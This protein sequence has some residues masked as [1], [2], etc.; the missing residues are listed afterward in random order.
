MENN[1]LKNLVLGFVIAMVGSTS[2]FADYK[3]TTLAEYRQMIKE[4][5]GRCISRIFPKD[6]LL[7][8]DYALEVEMI[9]IETALWAA[10]YRT[11]PTFVNRG[12]EIGGVCLI[13]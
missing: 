13:K 12:R 4:N 10:Y 8:I 2:A 5:E 3:K 6:A 1:V 7:E 9:D 11:F